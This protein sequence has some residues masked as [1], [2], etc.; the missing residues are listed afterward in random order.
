ANK[1]GA[2]F[3][4]MIA[5]LAADNQSVLRRDSTPTERLSLRHDAIGLV[6]RTWQTKQ[7]SIR[8]QLVANEV[9][10]QSMPSI[11]RLE[12]Q[13]VFDESGSGQQVRRWTGIRSPH[14]VLDYRIPSGFAASPP[15]TVIAPVNGL[16]AAI[17]AP[18]PSAL[19]V[20]FV[21]T[22]SKPNR[23][24]G[25]VEICGPLGPD[26]GFVGFEIRHAFERAFLMSRAAV[27]QTYNAEEWPTEYLG[28]S[29]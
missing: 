28:I 27:E 1:V 29:V 20:G 19:P 13:C 23:V 6:F 25:Y 8:E 4:Q 14:T 12:L 22:S 21:A 2:Q 17:A 24:L 26:T 18:P 11:E 10:R 3:D 9:M 7:D 15:G 16:V 5:Y